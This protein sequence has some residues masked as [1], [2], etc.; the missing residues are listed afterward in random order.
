M[1]EHYEKEVY[2]YP[3]RSRTRRSASSRRPCGNRLR[4]LLQRPTAAGAAP[5]RKVA[6]ARIIRTADQSSQGAG[7]VDERIAEAVV[8]SQPTL[9]RVRKQYVKEGLEAILNR[10]RR[11]KCTIVYSTANKRHDLSP[12]PAASHPKGRRKAGWR[13]GSYSRSVE[14]SRKG[15][16]KSPKR[17]MAEYGGHGAERAEPPVPG[18]AGTR[19]RD[20]TGRDVGVAEVP[21]RQG[22]RDRL[23]V[24]QRRCSHEAQAPLPFNR[25]VT[26]Y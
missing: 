17:Q 2:R 5:A 18:P 9:A 6:H 12:C 11:G 14:P 19:L 15:G 1:L 21:R 3:D 26:G 13:T 20:P 7:W 16:A 25:G 24:H 10:R 8:V 22:R 4:R 23:E